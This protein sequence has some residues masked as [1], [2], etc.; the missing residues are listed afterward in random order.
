MPLISKRNLGFTLVELAIVL[1]IMALL[2]GGLMM[3]VG[4]QMENAA[5]SETQRRLSEARDALLGFTAANGRL[6]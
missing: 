1:I 4:T 2:S 5:H 3:T 6:P